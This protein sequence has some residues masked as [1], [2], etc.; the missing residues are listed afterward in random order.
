MKVVW[1]DEA[2]AHLDGIYQYIARDAPLYAKRVVDKLTRR[3]QQLI[4]HPHSGRIVPEYEDQ[5]LREL[6]VSPYRLVYRVKSD[7]LD[8]IAVFH[9]AQQMPDSL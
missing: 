4:R 2:Q 1:T 5:Q 3:S 9:G 6:I 7:R 8:V